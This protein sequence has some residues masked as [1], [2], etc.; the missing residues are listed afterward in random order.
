MPDDDLKW[1][2]DQPGPDFAVLPGATGRVPLSAHGKATGSAPLRYRGRT[3]RR[4]FGPAEILGKFA[5]AV[6]YQ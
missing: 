3:P 2:E 6:L 1:V 5:K 4:H